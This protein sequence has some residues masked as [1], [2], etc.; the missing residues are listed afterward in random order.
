MNTRSSRSYSESG[1]FHIFYK[2]H[3][4]SFED[5]DDLEFQVSSQQGQIEI[6]RNKL[7]DKNQKLVQLRA[8]DS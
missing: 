1:I 2:I 7:R 8:D 4:Q 6:L 5:I 3:F